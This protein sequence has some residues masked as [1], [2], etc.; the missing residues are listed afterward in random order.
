V[1][2]TLKHAQDK[3]QLIFEKEKEKKKGTKCKLQKT[4]LGEGG[5]K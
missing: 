1:A 5:G 3:N 4:H 2:N